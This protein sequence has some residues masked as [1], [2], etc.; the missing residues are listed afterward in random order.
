MKKNE[1]KTVR[2][3]SSEELGKTLNDKK[4]DLE[5]IQLDLASGKEKNLKKVKNL[6]R[7]IAQLLTVINEKTLIEA[8]KRPV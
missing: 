1:L 3:K 7:E 4:Q 2:A 8:E 6:K 5:K